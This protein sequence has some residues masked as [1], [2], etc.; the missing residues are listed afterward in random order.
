MS[1]DVRCEETGSIETLG[2]DFVFS[3]MPVDELVC[4]LGDGV[5]EEVRGVAAGLEFRDF[6]TVGLLVKRMKLG[7]G[8]DGLG[9][10]P[11][12]WFYIQEPSVQLGRLQMYN[13]WSGY[14]VADR[15]KVW[16]GL[17]YFC[18]REDALWQKT[19]EEMVAFAAGELAQIGFIDRDD[20]ID[21]TVQRVAKAYPAYYGAYSEF[22]V[23]RGYLDGIENLY[24]VGRN[25]MH[26]YN[27]QDHSML[28]AM[29]AVDNIAAGRSGKDA[30]WEVNTDE[31]WIEEMALPEDG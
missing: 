7:G 8:A 29:A 4:A 13:N 2:G 10:P 3:T 22:G 30:L 28:T 20:L 11:D 17:E 25:G 26:K 9:L 5:P 27:N 16:L 24:L 31:E 14:M 1:V 23:V 15:E 19:D 21:G 6:M 12:N 18:N